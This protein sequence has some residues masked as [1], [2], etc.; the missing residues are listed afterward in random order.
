MVQIFALLAST[1]ALILASRPAVAGVSFNSISVRQAP[2]FDPSMIPTQCSNDNTGCRTL[3]DATNACQSV[4]CI[5]TDTVATNMK[6][7]SE[8]VLKLDVPG[9]NQT[10]AEQSAKTVMDGCKAAGKPITV[11]IG[12]ASSGSTSPSSQTSSTDT[13]DANN[14]T[15]P[16]STNG[17][18]RVALSSIRRA[19]VFILATVL[20]PCLIYMI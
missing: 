15:K 7:C 4:D 18:T 16:A 14:T 6:S 3:M 8:C 11:D 10:V 5:C 9:F 12:F 2:G 13:K 19:F 17:C 20:N 1:V